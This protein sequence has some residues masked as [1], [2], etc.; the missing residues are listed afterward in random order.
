MKPPILL[1]SLLQSETRKLHTSRKDICKKGGTLFCLH[2]RKGNKFQVYYRGVHGT[3]VLSQDT[4]YTGLSTYKTRWLIGFFILLSTSNSF[5]VSFPGLGPVHEPTDLSRPQS[6]QIWTVLLVHP[7]SRRDQ[8]QPENVVQS[9]SEN[10]W[11]P[12]SYLSYRTLWPRK[13]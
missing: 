1:V 3:R 4:E 9:H 2:F 7:S 5:P 11:V 10:K 8:G 6:E 12:G 13:R